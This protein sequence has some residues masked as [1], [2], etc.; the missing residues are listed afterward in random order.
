MSSGFSD[1]PEKTFSQ[2][3]K[4]RRAEKGLTQKQLSEQLNIIPQAISN[5]EKGHNLPAFQVLVRL[6][7]ALDVSLD[8]LVGR[9]DN[10]DIK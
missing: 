9:S 1:S 3:L 2:R 7:D 6:A 8:Y 10:P 4:D 5:F